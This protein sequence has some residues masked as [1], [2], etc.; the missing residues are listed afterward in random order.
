MKEVKI[1]IKGVELGYNDLVDLSYEWYRTNIEAGM[2]REMAR[3]L[4]PSSMFTK[5][6]YK[7]NLRS[8]FHFLRERMAPG[9]QAEI[10]D[11]AN[12]IAYIVKDKFP[13]CYE[14]FEQYTDSIATV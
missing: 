9:A 14:C 11:Y 13:I 5:F 12:A 8:I 6:I 3:M 2:S 4:L 10:R 1:I 7:A